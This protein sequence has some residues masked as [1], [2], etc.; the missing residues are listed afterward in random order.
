MEKFTKSVVGLA[1]LMV[2][3][4]SFAQ[5]MRVVKATVPFQ[6]EAAGKTLPAGDYKVRYDITT[7]AVT[8][9]SS[10]TRPA[11]TLTTREED[12]TSE[13][14]SYLRFE[15]Y[16]ESWTLTQASFGGVVQTFKRA[17]HKGESLRTDRTHSQPGKISDTQEIAASK[18][19]EQ[20]H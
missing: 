5:S 11:T 15:R 18:L 20:G 9:T 8:L 16:G 12:P 13:A 2:A 14:R 19:V 4:S 7:S 17:G 10:A 3:G 6:F 1:L